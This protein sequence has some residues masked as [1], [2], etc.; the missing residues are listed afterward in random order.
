MNFL[1][2]IPARYASTRFPGKPLVDIKGKPMVQ[3]TYENT[4]KALDVV[5]V[6]TDDERIKEAVLAFGGNVV[7]TSPDHPSGTDRCAEAAQK[8]G[9]MTGQ[10]FDVVINVQ[11]DEPFINPAQIRELQSCFGPETELATLVSEATSVEQLLNPS[12]AKV[13]LDNKR[14]AILFSRSPIPHVRG[15]EQSEWLRRHTFYRHIGMYGY[16]MDVLHQIT[17]LTASALEKAESLEQL[18]WIENGYTIACGITDIESISVDTP[19][20]LQ[21]ILQSGQ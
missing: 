11:G 14:N 3:W 5:Y 16:R 19:G 13:V 7:M 4:K 1:G 2:I 6:A 18:R 20:D 17:K 8:I 9:E 15:V 12:E 21:N 10:K